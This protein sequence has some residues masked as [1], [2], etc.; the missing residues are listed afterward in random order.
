MTPP[1]HSN[2]TTTRSV[3]G[4][5]VQCCQWQQTNFQIYINFKE[6]DDKNTSCIRPELVMLSKIRHTYWWHYSKLTK[7]DLLPSYWALNN[8][9]I[10]GGATA[11]A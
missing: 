9:K 1:H 3:R 4:Y 7:Y 10:P 5:S 8:T 11:D 2:T 6:S